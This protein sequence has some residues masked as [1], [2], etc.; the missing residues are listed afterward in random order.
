MYNDI[1]VLENMHI[2]FAYRLL[3][4]PGHD[5]FGTLSPEDVGRWPPG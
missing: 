1:S 5:L 4:K 2:S 3:R